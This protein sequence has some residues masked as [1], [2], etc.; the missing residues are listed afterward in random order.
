MA[1]AY[2]WDEH[3][4]PV[5]LVHRSGNQAVQT[6]WAGSSWWHY[7]HFL[8]RTAHGEGSHGLWVAESWESQAKDWGSR[9]NRRC[10]R[11]SIL[12]FSLAWLPWQVIVQRCLSAKNMSHVKA[13]CI[14]CG[15]FKLLP[16]FL[17]VMTGM[18]SRIL[19]TGNSFSCPHRPRSFYFILFFGFE[20]F[21]KSFSSVLT[22]SHALFF[23]LSI[24]SLIIPIDS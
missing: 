11:T 4:C 10:H 13:G 14:L 22:L 9:G 7:R 3:S 12:Y 17:M 5:V 6:G 19:Y 23:L 24:S 15:Y 18:V 1:W 16:M 21:P 8:M 2:L 20:S